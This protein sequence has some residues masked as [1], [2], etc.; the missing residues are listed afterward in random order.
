MGS[1]L[2]QRIEKFSWEEKKEGSERRVKEEGKGEGRE[3][4]GKR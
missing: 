3:E 4:Q 2:L 1:G